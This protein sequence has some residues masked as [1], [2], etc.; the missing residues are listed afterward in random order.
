MSIFPSSVLS[1]ATEADWPR[2]VKIPA[3]ERVSVCYSPTFSSLIRIDVLVQA[4]RVS[5]FTLGG[6][7]FC[8]VIFLR[9]LD[10]LEKIVSC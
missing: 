9:N 10:I 2:I 7:I 3:R 4:S 6:K 8:F 1:V 5:N